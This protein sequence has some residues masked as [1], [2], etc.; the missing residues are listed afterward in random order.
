MII[1]FDGNEANVDKKVGVSVYAFQ[2]LVNFYER[3][4][5]QTRFLIYLKEKP[6]SFLPKPNENF[7]YLIVGPKFLWSQIGL[8]FYLQTHKKPDVFFSPAHYSPKGIDIPKVITIHD[9]AYMYFPEEFLKKDLYKLQ[10]WTEISIHEAKSVIAVSE[11]TKRDLIKFHGLHAEQIKVIYN[12]YERKVQSSTLN[13][14][15]YGS[16]LSRTDLR[17]GTGTKFKINNPYILFVGTLQPR[18]NLKV[19]I[20]AFKKFKEFY[21]DFK[22]VLTGKKG[23]LYQNIFDQIKKFRL[24]EEVI[25]TDYVS[26]DELIHLYKNA[27]CFVLPSLYEGFGIPILEAMSFNCPVISSSS[28]SLPEVGGNACLY[29]KA[30]RENDLV[31]KLKQLRES[32]KLRDDLIK[33]GKERLKLF[34]WQKCADQTLEVIKSTA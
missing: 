32:K 6:K 11:N 22:L 31:D 12:G 14:N 9:M 13:Q 3:V 21:P 30:E 29:F 28:S 2:L 7:K 25:Y 26:D 15:K 24:T 16:G 8:P 34:S 5:N 27:F 4:N 10:N 18:K 20:S 1:G 17:S 19:L 23:W 33:K